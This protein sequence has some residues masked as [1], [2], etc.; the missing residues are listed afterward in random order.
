MDS[1]KRKD[2]FV[3]I[4]Q[5]LLQKKCG[6]V[7]ARLADKL[8]I[9]TSRISRWLSGQVDPINLE[10]VVFSRVA[11]LKGCSSE[12]LGKILGFTI[13]AKD[14]ANKFKL[15]IEQILSDRTQ[16][17]LGKILGITQNA[18]SNWLNPEKK[19]DP[20]RIPAITMFAIAHEKGWTFDDLLI[21][22]G[23]KDYQAEEKNLL[24]K[25]QSELP[26][27]SLN[28]QVILLDWLSDLIRT[29]VVQNKNID[30]VSEE[31]SDRTICIILEK[32][33]LAIASN[34]ASNLAIHLN[35][36][37][38]N[39]KVTTIPKLPESIADIDILI[40]DISTPSSASITLIEDIEGDRDIVVFV[41]ADLPVEVRS[42]LENR[43]TDLLVKPIDWQVL[44]DKAYFI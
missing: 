30:K 33:D 2:K 13:L 1:K 22:L 42:S 15:I 7:Q 4:L 17:Q 41:D 38:E 16:E 35:L 27:L 28:E 5:D 34:Y 3:L 11:L 31:I 20:G 19:I 40:F 39:I 25:Y 12:E 9:T 29:K 18:I 10:T 43:V 24:I 14:S 26:N 21:Y 44:K 37:P 6:G 32:E 23:L 8:G 36:K